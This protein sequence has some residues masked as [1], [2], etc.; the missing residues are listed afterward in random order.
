MEAT[1]QIHLCPYGNVWKLQQNNIPRSL[2]SPV[3]I[4]PPIY[5]DDQVWESTI[6]NG[7]TLSFT[8]L[9][10]IYLPDYSSVACNP[11]HRL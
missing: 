2:P 4:S 1:G 9:L 11:D 10:S 3:Y 6:Y 8:R 7:L 5:M